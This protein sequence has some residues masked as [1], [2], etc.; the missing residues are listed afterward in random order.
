MA[1]S[2]HSIL[3][4]HLIQIAL[5]AT[6]CDAAGPVVPMGKKSSGSSSLQRARWTQSKANPPFA[7]PGDHSDRGRYPCR[8]R[9]RLPSPHQGEP[10][11]SADYTEPRFL[12]TMAP[13]KIDRQIRPLVVAH[14]GASA[15]HPENTIA[16]FLGAAAA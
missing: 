5:A 4:S 13:S 7:R 11:R 2:R 1:H 10:Q 12:H 15:D 8:A 14:R 16:S 3:T 6:I 9:P